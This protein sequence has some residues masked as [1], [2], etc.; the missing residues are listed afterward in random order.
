MARLLLSSLQI[1][2]QTL[3]EVSI[4]RRALIAITLIAGIAVLSTQAVS[5]A[6]GGY[7]YGHMNNGYGQNYNAPQLTPEKQAQVDELMR[8]HFAETEQLRLEIRTNTVRLNALAADPATSEKQIRELT[9][10][11]V[12]QRAELSEKRVELD[13][14]LS[15][16]TGFTNFHHGRGYGM[17]GRGG[18]Q[19]NGYGP[20]GCNGCW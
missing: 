20:R 11:L 10:K 18:N 3:Q 8:K 13:K 9:E 2:K 4:M 16:I 7:G 1:T 19:G 6:R 5:W 17:G 15:E 12:S 14:K